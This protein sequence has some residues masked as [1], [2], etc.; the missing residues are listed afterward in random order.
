MKGEKVLNVKEMML[1]GQHNYTNASA[2]LAL[3]D[4]VGLPRSSS[5]KALTTFTGSRTG[6]SL[7]WSTTAYAG[8]TIP[9]RPTWVAPRRH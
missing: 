1:S 4:A 7:R 5:L 9:K 3:A 6:S 8:L 2:A